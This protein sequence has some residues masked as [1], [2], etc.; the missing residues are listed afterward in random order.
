MLRQLHEGDLSDL[1]AIEA[2]TQY[3]PWT[4]DVFKQC[5]ILGS[6]G[7]VMVVE[8]QVVG[9][10]ILF[11]KAGEGHILNIG[12][13]P[14]YQRRGY[15]QRLLEKILAVAQEQALLML[16]LEV[17]ISNHGALALYEKMGF[18]QIGVRKGYYATPDGREDAWVLMK[19][20][21]C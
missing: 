5:V 17:R 12:V 14:A 7:W 20:W 3:A 13:H 10:V 1:V 4:E 19:E 8:E 15:G 18:K 9:F 6:E 11:A 16:Y 2:A 21:Q